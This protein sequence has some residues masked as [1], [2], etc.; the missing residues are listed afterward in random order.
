MMTVPTVMTV[1]EFGAYIGAKRNYAY[2]L[3]KTGR[4]VMAS[5]GRHVMVSESIARIEAT[6]DPSKLG[7]A[8]RHAQQRGADANTGHEPVFP[9]LGGPSATSPDDGVG[10]EPG[11][12]PHAYSYQEAKAKREHWA[13]EREHAAYRKEAG[14]LME[15]AV[16]VAAFADAGA[17]MR[18]KLEAWAAVLPVQL[19]GRE[20]GDIRNILADQV[21]RLLHEL[22]DKFKRMAGEDA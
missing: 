11:D 9:S 14:E 18:G 10:G 12:G 21:E 6:R 2:E 3:K 5:D 16:V 20:E 7:V 13:A 22:V 15:R 1:P 8:Q 19:A 4:L 17:T